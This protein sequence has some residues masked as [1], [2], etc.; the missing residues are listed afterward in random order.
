MEASIDNTV[1]IAITRQRI[2]FNRNKFNPIA[3]VSEDEPSFVITRHWFKKWKTIRYEINNS[4]TAYD[5]FNN[6]M[7]SLQR[8]Q[9]IEIDLKRSKVIKIDTNPCFACNYAFKYIVQ[10]F[11]RN[12]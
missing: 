12:V 1:D 10:I 8:C 5:K 7:E 3:K 6:I 11:W 9:N 2:K 4:T